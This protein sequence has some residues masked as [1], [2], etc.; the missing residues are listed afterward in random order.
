MLDDLYHLRE[1]ARQAL[2]RGDLDDAGNSLVS[3]ASQTHVAEHDYVSVLRP[4]AEVLVKRG[5]TRSALTVSGTWRP[6]RARRGSARRRCC[7]DVPSIDRA[8]TL[9]ALS[10]HGRRGAR[11]GERRARRGGRDLPRE[12]R[13]LA[14]RARALVAPRAGHVGG[15]RRVQRARSCSSTSRAARSSAATC[16][17][18]ARPSSPRCV[19][20]EEAAD[21]F[22]RVGQRERAF[23][24]FQVLVQIGRES[25]DVRG[26]AR[27]LRQLHPDPARGPPQVLRAPVLRG[28]ARAAKEQ[29]ELSAAATLAREAADYARALGMARDERRTTSSCRPSSGA[30]S[31][32]STSSAAR[33]PRSRRTRCSRRSSRSARSVTTRASGDSTTSSRRWSSRPRARKHYARAAK[34]YDGVRDEP[35]DT[36]PLP[37]APPAGQPLPRRVARRPHRVG[38]AR[39]RRRSVRRRAARQALAGS[40]PPQGDA[41]ATHRVRG[42]ERIRRTRSQP[43]TAARVRLAD[44][45][46]QLQL[47][48]RALAAREALHATRA[49]RAHRGARRDA[50]ALLQAQ[51][52]HG[53]HGPPRRGP[54]GRRASAKARRSR[55]TFQHAFDPLSRIVRES[56]QRDDAR[57]RAAR[58]RARR[59]DGG[60]RVPPRHARARRARPIAP[61]RST[62]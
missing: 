50:A 18:R 40:H 56:P 48:A 2:A 34:R 60:R 27:G 9:A 6:D 15:R 36:A 33:R 59:H 24:C 26:R 25:G 43:A 29:H 14:R 45:L 28:R 21:H 1:R 19:S 12:G 7:T 42:R 49:A 32:S 44:Q 38:A 47:Y 62:A 8:R 10:R 13:R 58:A 61:R 4:L 5:D 52:R 54:R 39:Q 31:R 30:T 51:L 35:I 16:G 3:A 37:I 41:R 46:A 53:A 57:R 22:E 20:L 23:D 11:D 17:K 55:C